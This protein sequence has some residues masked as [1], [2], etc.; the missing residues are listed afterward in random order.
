MELR[1]VIRFL[2]PQCLTA[3]RAILGGMALL[4]AIYQ[5]AHW[6][7]TY[8]TYGALTDGLD[9]AAARWLKST[10]D[11]GVLFDLFSDYLCYIVAP[12]AL[13]LLILP[14]K[15]TGAV[16]C[17][18]A[19]PLLTGA[20]RYARNGNWGK[21]QEFATVGFPG[22][23][24]VVYAFF[25]VTLVFTDLKSLWGIRFVETAMCIVIPALSILTTSSL[26]YP[27]LMKYSW[28]FVIIFTAFMVMPFLWTRLL[29][30]ISLSLGCLY[31][32][33]SP[34]LLSRSQFHGTVQSSQNSTDD[35]LFR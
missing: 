34:F 28:F 32:V 1:S 2:I 25:I 22:I 23:G 10:S 24:T 17:L 21:T 26:R 16:L 31:T 6:A 12:M 18:L 3:S 4:A 15:P 5:E 30:G 9:G 7:A 20:I 29:A 27:K 33:L 35:G 8:I 14:E 19:L 11:F 13:S